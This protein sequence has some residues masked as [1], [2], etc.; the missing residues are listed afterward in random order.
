MKTYP[1]FAHHL[2]RLVAEYPVIL[3]WYMGTG[4]VVLPRVRRL[5]GSAKRYHATMP[6]KCCDENMTS[7]DTIMVGEWH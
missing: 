5:Y 6:G 2:L 1:Q 7:M 3:I 4:D